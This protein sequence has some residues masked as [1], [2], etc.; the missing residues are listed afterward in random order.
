MNSFWRISSI[1]NRTR[2]SS[3][4]IQK[5]FRA[6]RFKV[7]P[8][9]R[10]LFSSTSKSFMIVSLLTSNALA[11]FIPVIASFV[12]KSII[13]K[14][15][16]RRLWSANISKRLTSINSLFSLIR[17]ESLTLSQIPW[18]RLLCSSWFRSINQSRISSRSYLIVRTL[19]LSFSAN[20]LIVTGSVISN[21]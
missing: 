7:N 8:S 1:V 18:L 6:W 16:I 4:M 21:K 17:S 10:K 19:T 20:C 13:S 3:P 14:R 11:I 5:P 9:L 2:R 12:T 15:L